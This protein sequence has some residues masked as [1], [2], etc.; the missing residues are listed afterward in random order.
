M[1]T[2]ERSSPARSFIIAT[3]REL[4]SKL[5]QTVRLIPPCRKMRMPDARTDSVAQASEAYIYMLCMKSGQVRI[6]G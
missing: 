6:E 2:P 1:H 3:S 5:A 4:A